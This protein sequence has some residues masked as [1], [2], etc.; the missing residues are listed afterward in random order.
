M[1]KRLLKHERPAASVEPDDEL[2]DSLAGMLEGKIAP[3]PVGVLDTAR[4][5]IGTSRD[6]HQGEIK[7]LKKEIE[8]LETDA[9]REVAARRTVL[10]E[11]EAVLAAVSAYEAALPS[12]AKTMAEAAE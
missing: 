10:A 7:R 3:E 6:W 2:A 12:V 1:L 9:A 11:H 8:I 5:H 4:D